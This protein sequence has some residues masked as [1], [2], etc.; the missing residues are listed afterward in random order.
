MPAIPKEANV[1]IPPAPSP[2][3]VDTAAVGAEERHPNDP[4]AAAD[5]AARDGRRH[6]VTQAAAAVGLTATGLAAGVVLESQTKLS[7]KLPVRRR[8]KRTQAVRDAIAK[9]LA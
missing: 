9:R 3:D 6:T 1:S 4:P 7:R 5:G 8:P 2:S